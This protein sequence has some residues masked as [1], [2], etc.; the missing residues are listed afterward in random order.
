MKRKVY[1]EKPKVE[2]P[3]ST[4]YKRIAMKRKAENADLFA[5]TYVSM[6]KSMMLG[7]QIFFFLIMLSIFYQQVD[8]SDG[9]ND[10]CT[11]SVGPDVSYCYFY[12][13][14][15]TIFCSSKKKVW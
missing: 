8:H 11:L 1:L 15:S 7:L 6:K 10:H 14:Q 2:I 3:R 13:Y 5:S 4:K 12:F 9:V